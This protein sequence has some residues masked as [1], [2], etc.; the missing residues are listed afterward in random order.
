MGE[1]VGKQHCGGAQSA[2]MA[3]MLAR[4]AR[5][6]AAGGGPTEAG[7]AKSMVAE[8]EEG[9]D[10]QTRHRGVAASNAQGEPVVVGHQC[11]EN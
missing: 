4:V 7:G 5:A 1:V 9:G 6:H 11:V 8:A 10:P 3:P 2:E